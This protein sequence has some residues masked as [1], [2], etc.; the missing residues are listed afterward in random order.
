MSGAGEDRRLAPRS[1]TITAV[2]VGTSALGA[3]ALVGAPGSGPA[4]PGPG[5]YTFEAV[6]GDIAICTGAGA[7]LTGAVGVPALSGTSKNSETIPAGQTRDYWCTALDT[8]FN[9]IASAAGC[10][11][12]YRRSSP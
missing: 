4:G 8:H 10:T 9:A 2:T 7:T 1:G 12:A 6:G 11:L 5:Y 3:T